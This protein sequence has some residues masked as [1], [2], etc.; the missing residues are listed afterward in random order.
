MQP[1]CPPHSARATSGSGTAVIELD[2]V[3]LPLADPEACGEL[4]TA[5]PLADGEA[6]ACAEP[7]ALALLLLEPDGVADPVSGAEPEALALLLLEPDGVADT[8]SGA[9]PEALA[10][11]EV[12]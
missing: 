4:E 6:E 12:E 11:E 10:V 9:E 2:G 3:L 8:V 5:L 7:E 1:S